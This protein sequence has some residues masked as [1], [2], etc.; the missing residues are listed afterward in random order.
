M[1]GQADPFAFTYRGEEL[2]TRL[3]TSIAESRRASQTK[4]ETQQELDMTLT[5]RDASPSDSWGHDLDAVC[6][7]PDFYPLVH[8]V[9]SS[10][11]QDRKS[12]TELSAER[13]K[14]EVT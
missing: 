1:R 5:T 9:E 2:R 13:R 8:I 7:K 10:E 4:K 3:A 11:I 12:R 14:D 6:Q